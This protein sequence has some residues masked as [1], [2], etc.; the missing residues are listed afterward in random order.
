[1]Y[2]LLRTTDD[3]QGPT[4]WPMRVSDSPIAG[5]TVMTQAEYN[6]YL[7]AHQSAYDAYMAGL[8]AAADSRVAAYLA[9]LN[10]KFD[11]LDANITTAQAALDNWATQ[12]TTLAQLNAATKQIGQYLVNLAKLVQDLKPGLRA[13]GDQFK[14]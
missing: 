3:A 2:V 6:T 13:L 10:T 1:M 4:G 14:P 8:Q 7:A 12:V 11:T 9:A 5:A